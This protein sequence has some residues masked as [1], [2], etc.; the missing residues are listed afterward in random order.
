V[1]IATQPSVTAPASAVGIVAMAASA[2]GL[3]ALTEVLAAL[4]PDFPAPIVVVQHLDPR[5]RSL[6]AHILARRVRL[7]VKEAEQGE[8]LYP[9]TVYI[10]PPDRH[11]IAGAGGT[12]ALADTALVHF[13]RPSADRL[14]ET[15]AD[16]YAGR[17]VAVVLTGTGRDGDAGVCA[18][19]AAGGIVI[20]QDPETCEFLGMPAA[21]IATGCVDYVLPLEGI[22]P[23]LVALAVKGKTP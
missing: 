14:F 12:L 10:A 23:A 16:A 9:G 3:T 2:G 8:R 1:T 22:G 18:V 4:P 13:V 21:A 7:R 15:A 11:V 17:A 20:A 19:K 6:M 5:H